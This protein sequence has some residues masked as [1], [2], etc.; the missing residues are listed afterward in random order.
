MTVD[1][2]LRAFISTNFHAA[3]GLQ[4]DDEDSLLDRGVIDST[5]VL[6]LV[7]FLEQEFDMQICDDEI[8]PEN[9]DSIACVVRFVAFK[10][11]SAAPLQLE[12]QHS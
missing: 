3:R 6:E 7:L 1:A 9:L 10:A 12:E 4:L 2:R 11:Q 8:V 5:G